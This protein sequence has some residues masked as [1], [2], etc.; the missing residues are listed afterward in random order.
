MTPKPV[1][2]SPGSMPRMRP[3][4]APGWKYQRTEWKN[5]GAAK[6]SGATRSSRPTAP[7]TELRLPQKRTPASFFSAFITNSPSVPQAAGDEAHAPAPARRLNGVIQNSS[8]PTTAAASAPASQ[9]RYEN[10]R[11]MCR[12]TGR[13]RSQRLVSS[14]TICALAAT[15]TRKNSRKAPRPS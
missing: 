8:A 5:T 15:M 4:T 9:A 13:R 12:A 10:E 6:H 1:V 2:C 14:C 7:V 3:F 11:S